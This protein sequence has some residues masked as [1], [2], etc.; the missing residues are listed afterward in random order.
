MCKYCIDNVTVS[1]GE[2][3]L[4][5]VTCAYWIYSGACQYL[6]LPVAYGMVSTASSVCGLSS[7]TTDFKIRGPVQLV[8][9][10]PKFSLAVNILTN[11]TN[12]ND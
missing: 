1:H 5:S 9:F 12:L 2:E 3:L 11:L 7:K 4:K 6:K 10:R 8:Q